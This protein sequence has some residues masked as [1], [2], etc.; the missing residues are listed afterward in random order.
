MRRGICCASSST[1][2][3]TRPP[4]RDLGTVERA[5][6]ESAL[7]DWLD[8]HDVPDPWD[9]APGLVSQGLDPGD[10]AAA[11]AVGDDQLAAALRWL[12]ARLPRA[13]PVP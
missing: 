8:E 2:P 5:D 13:Q 6:R 11:A 7:E 4:A 12:V 3:G 1:G 9:L 10:L